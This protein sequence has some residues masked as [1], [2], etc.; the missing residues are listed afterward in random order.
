MPRFK[1]EAQLGE[2]LTKSLKSMGVIKSF[3][4]RNADFSIMGGSPGDIYINSV[5]QTALIEVDEEGTVAAAATGAIMST[6]AMRPH[7]EK[8]FTVDR[9]FEFFIVDTKTQT[10]VFSGKVNSLKKEK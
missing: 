3:S 10:I 6:T 7:K 2:E 4:P 5:I 8:Q 1:V 9:P